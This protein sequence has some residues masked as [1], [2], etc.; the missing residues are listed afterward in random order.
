MASDT[1]TATQNGDGLAMLAGDAKLIPL[2]QRLAVRD[3]R[4]TLISSLA[5]PNS[6]A[7]PQPL[8]ALADRFI[9][10]AEGDR[11]LLPLDGDR[12]HEP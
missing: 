3:V 9:D 4:V 8:V 2:L 5:V 7:P 12:R 1:L 10:L 11:F 6:I